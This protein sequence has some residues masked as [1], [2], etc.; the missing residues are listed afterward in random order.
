MEDN[1]FKKTVEDEV[2]LKL[3]DQLHNTTLN[4]SNTSLEIKKFLFIL[5]GIAIPT[6]IKLSNDQLDI[7]LFVTLYFLVITFWFLD[8]FT[9]YYQVN[10]RLLMNKKFEDVLK[11]NNV[12][13]E[14][15]NNYQL[16]IDKKRKNKNPFWDALINSSVRIYMFLL[17]LNSIGL[18]LYLIKSIK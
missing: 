5:I 2:D 6:I 15:I 18:G 13:E 4:F 3:I 12:D 10:L 8:S 17:V 14:T 1:S 11:R 16:A 9:Y 7:S